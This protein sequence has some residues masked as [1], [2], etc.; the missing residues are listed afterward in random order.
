MPCTI[1]SILTALILLFLPLLAS[2]HDVFYPTGTYYHGETD[3]RVAA[4]GVPMVWER[5]YRSNRIVK[6]SPDSQTRD[7]KRPVDG[8]LDF[9]WHTPFTWGYRWWSGCE[10][11]LCGKF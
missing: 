5:T 11:S 2:A 8:P 3:L 4:R 1:R 9:G 10:E 7:F 6:R